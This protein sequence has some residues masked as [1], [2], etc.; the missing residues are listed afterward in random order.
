MLIY[1]N[2]D[3]SDVE[4]GES[5]ENLSGLA[6]ALENAAFL[7][8]TYANDKAAARA[9]DVALARH[10]PADPIDRARALAARS[11]LAVAMGDA[12]RA[13]A[14]RFE[15]KQIPLSDEERARF[16]HELQAADELER[17]LS[18]KE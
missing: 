10:E 7:R 17:W 9:L 11:E 13:Q 15:L 16:R 6:R 4:Y 12:E 3:E 2:H 8:D 18:H 5:D 1:I 14:V